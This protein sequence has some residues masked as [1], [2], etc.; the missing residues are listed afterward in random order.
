MSETLIRSTPSSSRQT[1]ATSLLAAR[2]R[3]A[4]ARPPARG[5]RASGAGSARRSTLPFGVS[6]SCVERDEQRRDHVVRQ[7]ARAGARAARPS[8]GAR[9]GRGDEVRHQP[10]L[11]ARSGLRATTTASATAGCRASAASI[12]PS[13][14]RIAA[15]LDLE[16]G[17]SEVARARRRRAS[18]PDRRCGRA[19]RPGV[20]RERVGDEALGGQLGAARD[21]RARRPRRRCTARP[22]RR[23]AP[24]RRAS[25]SIADARCC[26]SAG[27]SSTP[28]LAGVDA[29]RSVDQTVVS[30]GPYM[31][32]SSPTRSSSASASSAG[33]ASPPHSA[34]NA[35]A[36]A[37]AGLE[38]HAPGRRRRLHH[39][40]AAL[41]EQRAQRV[42]VAC[43]CRGSRARSRAPTTSGSSSSSTAMSNDSVVTARRRSSAVRPG[44]LAHRVEEVH[45]ARDA[46][47]ATPLGLPVE[48]EV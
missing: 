23:S 44:A 29:P 46:G 10:L 37:P 45:D 9:A 21:S 31:F 12:S 30:V 48:P 3:A 39:G 36:A 4:A 8:A 15:D 5:S 34:L 43:A 2:A 22:A 13:S 35:G 27:R 20:G 42:A 40:R 38:Q 19:A 32:H 47:R 6:G 7:R 25:S 1:V 18:A 41:L 28:P 14:M 16:V 11:A 33:S 17:A 26:R 24:A